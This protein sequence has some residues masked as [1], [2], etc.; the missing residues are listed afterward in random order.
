MTVLAIDT[1]NDCLGIALVD[2]TKIIGEYMTNLKKNHSV[3]AMPAVDYLLKECH[4]QPSDLTKIVVAQGPG[5]YTGVRIGVTIAKTLAWA[6]NIPLTGVSSLEVLALNG[7]FFDGLICPLFDARRGRVYTG[8]YEFKE[9]ILCV[10]EDRNIL[11]ED[12]LN[13]IKQLKKR[14]LFLGN[15]VSLHLD[16]IKE[17][18][19]ELAVIGDPSLH[20]PRPGLLG[21]LGM[22]R[23]AVNVHQFVPNYLRLAEAE[24]K[25]IEQQK[26][27]T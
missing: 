2:E 20:Q 7:R 5:S 27:S 10:K 26:T 23:E 25:W 8:L 22:T 1:S 9:N 19:G 6:R 3:R 24:A 21:L 4:V 17:I 18:M 12:W 15:D 11:L 16:L 13:E 14:V